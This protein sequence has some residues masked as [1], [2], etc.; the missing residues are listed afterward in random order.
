MSKVCTVCKNE[1]VRQEGRGR[2]LK[3]NKS[4]YGNT[5]SYSCMLIER[6]RIYQMTKGEDRL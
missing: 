6:Q 1:F 2:K 3:S 5:C 4:G